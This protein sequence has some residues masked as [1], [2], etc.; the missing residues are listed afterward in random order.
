[1]SWGKPGP[2]KWVTIFANAGHAWMMVAGLRFDTSG[3]RIDGSRWTAQS[4]STAGFVLR[5]PPGL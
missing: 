5:H 4:R 3:L 1:M 2:G